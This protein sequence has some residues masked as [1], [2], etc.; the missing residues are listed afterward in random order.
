MRIADDKTQVDLL[1]FSDIVSILM[2]RT[3]L[4]P[5]EAAYITVDSRSRE[6]KA[7]SW[8]KFNAKIVTI[9]AHL[10]KKG[11]NQGTHVLVLLPHGLE[12]VATVYAC[13]VL[14]VIVIPLAPPD[15]SRAAE[16]VMALLSLVNDFNINWVLVNNDSE[17]LLRS[18]NIQACLKNAARNGVKLP[19]PVN[20][21]KAPKLTKT[22]KEAHLA[23]R[24]EWCKSA[25]PAVVMCYLSDDMRISRVGL[26]HDTL[27]SL[28]QIQKQ[29]CNMTSARAVVSC[30]KC[31]TGIGFVHTFLLGVFMG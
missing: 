9:A 12:L 30:D 14:G 24:P 26:G 3:Q 16:D 27:M 11:C 22:L 29:T 10:L 2:W 13:M 21:S 8:K 20:V 1:K 28:C 4:A 18:K 23:I 19:P 5:D 6:G 25:R 15:V 7:V 17:N 31:Y